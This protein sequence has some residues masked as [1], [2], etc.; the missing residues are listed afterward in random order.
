MSAT[1]Q[2]CNT[3]INASDPTHCQSRD[4][5]LNCHWFTDEA[6]KEYLCSRERER[7]ARDLASIPLSKIFHN[8]RRLAPQVGAANWVF[9]AEL[10]GLD[11]G[12]AWAACEQIGIDPNEKPPLPSSTVEAGR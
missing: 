2:F 3:D 6:R 9:A 5:A 1:C 4:E 8:A 7:R 11:L 10:F 12:Y